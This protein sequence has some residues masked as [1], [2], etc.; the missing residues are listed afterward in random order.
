MTAFWDHALVIE[1]KLFHSAL[2]FCG[3][4]LCRNEVGNARLREMEPPRHDKL[5]PDLPEKGANKAI[6]TEYRAFIRQCI[7]ALTTKDDV[8][9]FDMPEFSRFLPDDDDSEEE[10]FDSPEPHQDDDPPEG[11]P[12]K[13]PK[14]EPRKSVPVTKAKRRKS[15]PPEA[16]GERVPGEGEGEGEGEGYGGSGDQKRGGKGNGGSGGGGGGNS[17]DGRGTG[18]GSGSHLWKQP[19]AI[20]FRGYPTDIAARNYVVTVRPERP[21]EQP[22]VLTLQAVGD[23]TKAPIRIAGARLAG[24]EEIPFDPAGKVGPVILSPKDAVRLEVTLEEP[25][26]LSIEVTAHE[27]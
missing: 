4:F 20:R 10:T 9:V 27:A 7:A 3:V 16:E 14:P 19:I 8:K 15:S 22:A 26:K 11:F 5:D 12:G 2:P 17:N 13:P 24:G 1:H 21:K 25:R 23:D 18:G 6:D